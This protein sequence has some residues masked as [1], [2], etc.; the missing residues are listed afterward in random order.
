MR[1]GVEVRRVHASDG[2]RIRALR[3]EALSDPA[4]SIAFLESR[5]DAAAKPMSFWTDRAIAGALSDQSAQFIAEVGAR[6]IATVTVLAPEAG[7]V[8]Y[9]GRAHEPAHAL[10]VSVYLDSAFRGQGILAELVSAAAQ[11]A[12]SHGRTALMLDV[13]H[14]NARAQAA[15]RALGF[16]L[17]G[18]SS[19]GPN[20]LELQ[21]ARDLHEPV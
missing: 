1:E 3:L 7:S 15:Y 12:L 10:L 11:W 5:A 16:T 18:E 6:W 14:D 2:A 20:G 4:A 19:V 13:H 9:F 8:D 21:M 17:T